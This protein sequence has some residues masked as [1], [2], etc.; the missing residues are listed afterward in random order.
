M[1]TIHLI[2]NAHIDPIWL[3][4]W[5]A[6]LDAILNTARSTCDLLDDY[7]FIFTRGDAWSYAMIEQTDLPLFAR[8]RS[9]IEAGRWEVVGG[10]WVQPD[11]NL[12]SGFAIERQIELGRSY[13]TSRFGRFPRI[14]YNVDSFGHAAALPRLMQQ[15]GQDRYVFMRPMPHEKQLPAR[16]FRWQGEPDGP[17]VVAFRIAQAY[18]TRQMTLDHI[19]ASLTDLPDGIDHTMCFIGVGDHGGGMTRR[20]LEWL[21]QCRDEFPGAELVFSTPSRFFEA[22]APQIDRLPLV[23]GELQYHAIGC[24]SVHRPVK[25]ATRRAEHRLRQAELACGIDEVDDSPLEQAWQN[26]CFAH[27]HDTLGGTCLPSAYP[28]V[29]AELGEAAAV[30]ERAIHLAMRRRLSALGDDPQP[31]VILWNPSDEPFEDYIEIEPW[32]EWQPW[33]PGWRVLDEDGRAIP[34]QL[35]EPEALVE[36]QNRLLLGLSIPA[37]EWRVLRIACDADQP[38]PAACISFASSPHTNKLVNTG[39]VG[40]HTNDD[41]LTLCCPW[42]DNP[43][44]IPDVELINDPSDTWSHGIDRYEEHP[45]ETPKWQTFANVDAGPL[46][47]SFRQQGHIGDSLL[48]REIRTFHDAPW[49]DIHWTV[50]WRERQKLLKLRWSPGITITDRID[51]VMGGMLKRALDSREYPLHDWMLLHC[52]PNMPLG[53]MCPDVYAADASPDR[54]RLTLLRSAWLA[55]H[56]PHDGQSARG[57]LSDQGVHHFR[58]RL[59]IGGDCNAPTL[60]RAATGMHRPPAVA[61]LTRGVKDWPAWPPQA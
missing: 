6:G 44:A 54:V 55:H 27:F 3:W 18:C 23:T 5:P 57:L 17:T 28:Q 50:H 2:A 52:E 42:S 30:A 34:I 40:L 9:H 14:A 7:P 60:Q 21:D 53:I 37:G 32:L 31:R 8:I 33:Q 46:M 61:E 16:L 24:Y 43:I 29:D 25:Q 1:A 56:E 39:G 12:P 13:F 22:I 51:G 41:K 38:D 45:L 59:Y 47:V 49:I 36:K 26:V 4:P 35:I 19:R 15:F 20:Q 10:W 48:Q 58:I 11:C